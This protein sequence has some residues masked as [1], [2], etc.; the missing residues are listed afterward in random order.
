MTDKKI[1]V[2]SIV[3]M[4]YTLRLEDDSVADSTLDEDKPAIFQMGAGHI[5]EAFEQQL[6]GLKVNDKKRITLKPQEAFGMP[7]EENIYT[8]P[9]SRFDNINDLSVGSIVAF[10]Q[11]EHGEIPG[12][13]RGISDGLVVVDF[14]HPLAGRQVTFDVQIVEIR[15]ND[16]E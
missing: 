6:L 7:L 9:S 3:I 4:H 14:N 16:T 2:N 15:D 11:G 8:V 12:I 13:I 10:S 5:S 1:E